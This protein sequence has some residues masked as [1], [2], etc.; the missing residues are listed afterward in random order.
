MSGRVKVNVSF[1]ALCWQVFSSASLPKLM[2]GGRDGVSTVGLLSL[3]LGWGIEKG[4]E[5]RMQ[6][7]MI[8]DHTFYFSSS[9][10]RQVEIKTKTWSLSKCQA[11]L[12]QAVDCYI[13]L[14]RTH[15]Y[16]VGKSQSHV[17]PP[18]RPFS[19]LCFPGLFPHNKFFLCIVHIQNSTCCF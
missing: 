17:H 12:N 13:V 10:R 7:I 3:F 9:S 8:L 1:K 18:F 4:V 15:K 11:N 14:S 16:P 5:Q 6:K 19:P 2:A